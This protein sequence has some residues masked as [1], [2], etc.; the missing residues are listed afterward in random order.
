MSPSSAVAEKHVAS[1]ELRV[2]GAQIADKYTDGIGEIKVVDSLMLP[3]S[4]DLTLFINSYDKVEAA[5]DVDGQPF[6]IG[7][8]ILLKAGAI[9]DQAPTKTVFDGDVVAVDADFGHGGITLGIR[10]LDRSHKLMRSRKV[11]VFKQMSTGAAIKKILQENGLRAGKFDTTGQQE[12][13]QQDNETDWEF[14]W[15]QA[16]G[17]NYW[18]LTEGDKVDFVKA[19]NPQTKTTIAVEWPETIAAFHPRVTGVQQV[20]TVTAAAWDPKAK[21]K[22]SGN[23]RP[24][25]PLTQIGLTRKKVSDELGGGKIHISNSSATSE[26]EVRNLADATMARLA[27]AY[28]EADAHIPGNPD[29][30]AGVVLD[31]KGVGQQFSGKYVVGTVRHTFR[32]GGAFDTYVSTATTTPSSLAALTGGNGA[33]SKFGDA[34]VIGL[35]TNNKDPDKLARV[36]VK[37]PALDDSL[38][39]DWLRIAT[40]NAGSNRGVLML[41]QVNDE[42]IVGFENGDTRRGYVLGSLWNGRDKPKADHL[43]GAA[44]N[45]GSF[46]VQSDKQFIATSQDEMKLTST[47]KMTIESKDEQ[48]IKVAKDRTEQV[49]GNLKD[50]VSGNIEQKAKGNF[51]NEATGSTTIKATGTVTLESSA[52]L[53][54]KAPSV[55]VE[56]QAQLSLK[57]PQVSIQGSAMVNIS[58]GIINLG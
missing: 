27:D 51:K 1:Y 49:Q 11:R 42:V 25:T 45:D 24:P 2:N 4:C 16:R 17:L 50:D 20:Q 14:I 29:V 48:L 44:E 21:Q 12:W 22:F 32:G 43:K 47:K 58:G 7:A 56:G 37:F 54:I 46:S 52:S 8:K 26:N 55:T 53:T 3:D 40:A 41:P 10:A 15:R 36:K 23:A 35:V 6:K 34:L 38:E 57:A 19:G 39:S 13:L 18:V 9:D 31:V 33:K 30:K 28:V 5:Q